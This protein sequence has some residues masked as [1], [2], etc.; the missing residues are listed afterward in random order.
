MELTTTT[1]APDT[2]A[3]WDP[4]ASGGDG[5]EFTQIVDT[6]RDCTAAFTVNNVGFSGGNKIPIAEITLTGAAITSNI[7]RRN[8]F[9]RLGVG[10]PA[11]PLNEFSW[12]NGQSEPNPDRI[13]NSNAYIGA[14]KAI[15]TFKEWMDAVMTEFKTL[16]GSAFWFS[17][18]SS[19][20][21]GVNLSDLFFDSVGSV[22]TGT[23]VFQHDG[24]TPGEITWTSDLLLTS[25]IGDL[26]LKIT[27]DTI[28]LNDEQVGFVQLVRNDVIVGPTFN[29]TSG[30]PT[31]TS[32]A[33]AFSTF[34]IGDWIKAESGGLASWAQIL[35]FNTGVPATAISVTLTGNYPGATISEAAVRTQEEYTAQ[36]ADASSVPE[37]SNVY[38][39]ARRADNGGIARVYIRNVGELES[40]EEIEISDQSSEDLLTYTGATGET[41]PTP[42]YAS[43]TQSS[44]SLAGQNFNSVNEENLTIR[45]AKVTAMLADHKQDFNI[46]LDPGSVTWDGATLDI[47]SAQLSIPGTTIGAAP[48]SINNFNAALAANSAVY[49][50]INRTTAGALTLVSATLASLTPSQQ[51]LVVA[52][53]IGSDIWVR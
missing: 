12:P 40:G 37:N 47:S 17:P 39:I 45:A 53:R 22:I 2:R 15:N 52:R 14:D 16:K 30:S 23:G 10:Q 9:F 31:V 24:G 7:D 27:A 25:M 8:L 43:Q 26:K 20:I 1:S 29:F 33:G 50:D 49:V 36:V 3:F 44:G 6:A 42:D 18:G 51:R 32:T 46:E 13:L 4:S 5:A 28:N 21:S 35:S 11:D 19:L 38:W 41:D 48:V 34:I